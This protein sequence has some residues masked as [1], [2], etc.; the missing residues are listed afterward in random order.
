LQT[1]HGELAFSVFKICSNIQSF[2][3]RCLPFQGNTV[4]IKSAQCLWI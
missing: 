4:A 2:L 3:S 1:F